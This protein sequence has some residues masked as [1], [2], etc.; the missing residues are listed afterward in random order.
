MNSPIA[1]PPTDLASLCKAAADNLRLDILRALARDSLGVLELSQVFGIKQ[2]L[3]SHHLKILAQVNLIASRREGNSIF[4]RRAPVAA[5]DPCSSLIRSLFACVDQ[6]RLGADAQQQL[7]QIQQERAKASFSFFQENASKFR[8][9]Q[10]LIASHD[11]YASV[12]RDWLL[13]TPKRRCALEVGPGEGEFLAALSGA[14]DQVIALDNSPDMLEKARLYC[15]K[16][17][18]SN[19]TPVCSALEN[20]Q[21]N[22]SVDCVVANMVL[23][24]VPSPPQ[25]IEQMAQRLLP[26][27]QLIISELCRHDQTWTQ[28]ACGDLWLGFDADDLALWAKEAGLVAGQS[29]YLALRNGF[30]IQIHQFFQP[31]QHR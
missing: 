29:S 5:A 21:P 22:A 2:S 4:Y 8:A 10:E 20:W 6:T 9:Q 24:H 31:S 14:F 12:A 11:V 28:D 1:H 30:Q 18:L 3:M 7:L 25:L 23:H 17:G 26:E 13:Q 19:V 16:L 27:G 15:Q